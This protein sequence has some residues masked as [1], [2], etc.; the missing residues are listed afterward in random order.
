MCE[1]ALSLLRT[2]DW[3]VAWERL[4]DVPGEIHQ[5]G[6][7]TEDMFLRSLETKQVQ[8]KYIRLMIV[9]DVGVGKTTLCLNLIDEKEAVCPTDGINV[10][11]QNYL[12]DMKT[13]KWRKL[14]NEDIHNLPTKLLS[15]VCRAE[16][17]TENKNNAET[18]TGN[19]N[20]AKTT[21]EEEEIGTE[22][23]YSDS[24]KQESDGPSPP[25]KR[26]RLDSEKMRNALKGVNTSGVIKDDDAFLSVWDFAGDE[27]YEATHHIFMSPDAVYIIVFNS[28]AC[29]AEESHLDKLYTWQEVIRTYST[30]SVEKEATNKTPPII[31]VGTHLDKIGSS[32]CVIYVRC[33][34]TQ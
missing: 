25:D 11:I 20:I 10:F 12:V 29:L 19:R 7:I 16:T 30:S 2:R 23:E 8:T 15:T 31:I 28:A 18:T 27:I 22:I 34:L 14:S 4:D 21:S 13:G 32:V 9:G 5:L 3:T 33:S 6:T 24:Q 1:S 17:T 26:R